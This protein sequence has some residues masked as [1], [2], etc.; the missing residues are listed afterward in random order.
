MAETKRVVRVLTNLKLT[1][2]IRKQVG[3]RMVYYIATIVCGPDCLQSG[4]YFLVMT[5][6]YLVGVQGIYNPCLT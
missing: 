2:Q 1:L 5:R 3:N 4:Q 6:Y